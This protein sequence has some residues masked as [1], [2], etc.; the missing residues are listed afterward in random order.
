MDPFTIAAGLG[1][2]GSLL[3]G[4]TGLFA[5]NTE[6]K[7]ERNAASQAE[8]EGGEAASQAVQSGNAAAASAAVQGAANGGGFVGSTLGVVQ[9]LANRA[10]FNARAAAYRGRVQA[11]NDMYQAGVAQAQGVQSLIGGVVGGA[12][13]LV[14]GFAQ[15]ANAAAQLKASQALRGYS[16]GAGWADSGVDGDGNS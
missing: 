15:S 10:M 7:A 3:K 9:D 1:A 8:A 11:Q 16:G 4:V 12:S 2:I 13:S 6:A 5:G 14:G